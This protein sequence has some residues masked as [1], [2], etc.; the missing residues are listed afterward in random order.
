MRK[1]KTGIYRNKLMTYSS[2]IIILEFIVTKWLYKAYND[3]NDVV[4]SNVENQMVVIKIV[5]IVEL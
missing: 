2:L 4:L 3:P 5:N 1:Q